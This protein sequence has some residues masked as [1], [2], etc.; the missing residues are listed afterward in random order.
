MKESLIPLL[1]NTLPF[2][3][4]ICKRSARFIIFCLQ[5]KVSLVRFVA[6]F[7]VFV[8]RCTS[9]LDRNVQYCCFNFGWNFER[10][11]NGD[12]SMSNNVF[13]KSFYLSVNEID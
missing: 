9:P 1:L 7:G 2:Y 5:S 6:R 8:N 10:F 3:D 4:D 12:I 11:V 13:V